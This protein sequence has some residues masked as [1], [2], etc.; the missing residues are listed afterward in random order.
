MLDEYV[1]NLYIKMLC[2][3]V[4][5]DNIPEESQQ[6]YL[7]RIV[8]GF[9]ADGTLEEYMRQALELSE[10]DVR[11]FFFLYERQQG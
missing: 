7:E 3:V 11:E 6:C 5:Y 8:R 4:Q 2:T 10:T 1:R 9:G